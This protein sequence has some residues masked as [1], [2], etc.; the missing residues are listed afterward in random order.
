MDSQRDTSIHR[1]NEIG[2]EEEEEAEEEEEEETEKC[3]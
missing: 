3:T 1:A 2:L